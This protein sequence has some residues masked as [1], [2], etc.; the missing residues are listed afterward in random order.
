MT[1]YR[2]NQ[3]S[4]SITVTSTSTSLAPEPGVSRILD[5]YDLSLIR[6]CYTDSIGSLTGAIA[7]YIEGKMKRGMETEVI[8]D[9]IEQTGWARRPSPHYFRAI[10]DRLEEQGIKTSRQLSDDKMRRYREREEANSRQWRKWY[11][12][13]DSIENMPF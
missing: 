7:Y 4:R 1:N 6:D 13:D 8:L 12:E 9:A 11:R 10:L 2:Q 5:P 3:D